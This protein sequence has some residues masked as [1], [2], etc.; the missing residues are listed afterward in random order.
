MDILEIC[1]QFL[2]ALS[3]N[4]TP[5]L[6]TGYTFRCQDRWPKNGFLGYPSGQYGNYFWR[7]AEKDIQISSGFEMR[8]GPYLL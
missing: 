5:K 1:C 7:G 6:K 3:E 4:S 8:H 2:D